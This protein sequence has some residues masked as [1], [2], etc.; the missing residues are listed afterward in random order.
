M[1]TST[2]PG[3]AALAFAALVGLGAPPYGWAAR[4]TPA[5]EAPAD[6]ALRVDLNAADADALARLPGIGPVRAQRILERRA[7]HPFRSVADLAA[8][9]G[10]GPK[11][12]ARLKPWVKVE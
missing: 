1:T 3:L 7:K 10:I 4:P 2:G 5:R 6:P 8:V 12:V 11:L 9:R